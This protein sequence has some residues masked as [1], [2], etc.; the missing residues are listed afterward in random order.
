ME[1]VIHR[2]AGPT[3]E[4]SSVR[5]SSWGSPPVDA[6]SG[7]SG[8]VRLGDGDGGARAA[9]LERL[10]ERGR[11]DRLLRRLHSGR[12]HPALREPAGDDRGRRG[13]EQC[14]SGDSPGLVRPGGRLDLADGRTAAP[15]AADLGDDVLEAEAVR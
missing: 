15:R 2:T 10:E 9:G 12:L 8:R 1:E 13:D 5:F 7:R 11:V 14:A 6:V 4:T 3:T